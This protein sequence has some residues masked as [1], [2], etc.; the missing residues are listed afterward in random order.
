MDDN[1]ARRFGAEPRRFGRRS[2]LAP[3]LAD[4][5]PRIPR[6]SPI[7]D[8]PP[9]VISSPDNASSREDDLRTFFGPN[10]AA[11]LLIYRAWQKTSPSPDQSILFWH[12]PFF[13]AAF[14]N[15]LA[16]FIPWLFYRKLYRIGSA[17]LIGTI[18]INVL[19]TP[20]IADSLNFALGVFFLRYGQQLYIDQ[21][22]RRLDK[23]DELGFSAT[24]RAAYLRRAGGRSLAAPVI[25]AAAA[26]L[27]TG[28]L[29]SM[30]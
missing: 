21:A 6:Q 15:G 4:P 29:L 3:A 17:V 7:A 22:V 5:P 9:A 19:V 12:R 11:Y 20:L 26:S 14:W 18:A 10:A 25:A 13:R 23:A 30:P 24:A 16:L 1:M 8:A 27:V 2:D 28:L